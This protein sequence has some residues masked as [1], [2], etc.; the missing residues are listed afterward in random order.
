MSSMAGGWQRRRRL[1]AQCVFVILVALTARALYMR[2]LPERLRVMVSGQALHNG[3]LY[4]LGERAGARAANS[5]PTLYGL[6][7]NDNKTH[8]LARE[9][10][11]AAFEETHTLT[12]VDG[13]LIYGLYARRADAIAGSVAHRPE[14]RPSQTPSVQE[15]GTV[16]RTVVQASL[17]NPL[18]IHVRQ[19]S[20]RDGTVRDLTSV[21]H[22]IN[23]CAPEDGHNVYWICPGPD[24][25]VRAEPWPPDPD[26]APW[27]EVEGHSDLM[28]T[29]LRDGST[30]RLYSGLTR[31]TQLF[32]AGEGVFWQEPHPYPDDKQ[33][34]Y[35]Y[36]ET[37][38]RIY[39]ARDST[40]FEHAYDMPVVY[41]DRFYWFDRPAFTP[42]Q[43]YLGGGVPTTPAHFLSAALDGSDRRTL[44]S[45]SDVGWNPISVM[46]PFLYHG[47][48]FGYSQEYAPDTPQ[49]LYRIHPE[50]PQ[51]LELVFRI[52]ANATV[53][54]LDGGY[55]YFTRQ[56]TQP[57]LWSSLTGD[58]AGA[59]SEDVLYR[60]RLPN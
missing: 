54:K 2:R 11:N 29:S 47:E 33:D 46:Y 56:E 4:W 53:W 50:R 37:E 52:P 49:R 21:E 40:G 48:L 31:T 36:H 8:V 17:P 35:Y 59:K 3:H 12:Y 27:D 7:F 55:L 16:R 41:Q 24:R 58:P 30:R 20:L 32:P 60:V 19:F 23:F 1:G 39:V 51:P 18:P 45:T 42:L 22:A 43:M 25:R 44:F 5:A 57:N 26:Q 9:A 15:T 10:P 14:F 34:L 13:S 38:G 28:I 6:A